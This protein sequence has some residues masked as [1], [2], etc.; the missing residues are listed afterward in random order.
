MVK[1]VLSSMPKA[2]SKCPI[3]DQ[4]YSDTVK[5]VQY[6]CPITKKLCKFGNRNS[7]CPLEEEP[8]TYY[9]AYFEINTDG[10]FYVEYFKDLNYDYRL[11][12]SPIKA[13]SVINTHLKVAIDSFKSPTPRYDYVKEK[14]EKIYNTPDLW[15]LDLSARE[16]ELFYISED[17]GNY[18][19]E[20][21]IRK[22]KFF[23]VK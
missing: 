3:V 21:S 9:L 6:H 20:Y 11:F 2:C 7:D 1:L 10:D 22:V 18:G 16:D 8:D 23:G 4:G 14:M 15:K 13:L 17:L 12:T 19:I 5:E